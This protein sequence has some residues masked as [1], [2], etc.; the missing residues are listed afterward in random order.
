LEEVCLEGWFVGAG[1]VCSFCS[2]AP[3][4]WVSYI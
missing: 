4:T 2:V 1:E 3:F